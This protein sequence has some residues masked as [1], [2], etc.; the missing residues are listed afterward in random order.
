MGVHAR[1]SKGL[2]RLAVDGPASVRVVVEA[3]EAL[4]GALAEGRSARVDL[5]GADS[6]DVAFSQLL[7]SS[8]RSFR[9]QEVGYEIIDPK[10]L[11]D[12]V[13]PGASAEWRTTLSH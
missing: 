12:D 6:L 11:L 7:V 4:L 2:L 8:E 1:R 5:S 3:R 9:E 13:F 10:R